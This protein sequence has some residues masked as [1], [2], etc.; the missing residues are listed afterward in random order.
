MLPANQPKY[1]Y[2]NF[3]SYHP[4]QKTNCQTYEERHNLSKL[5]NICK[6]QRLLI[7]L[8]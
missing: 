8:N 3:L 1:L 6:Y 4:C 7:Y 2:K 5:P